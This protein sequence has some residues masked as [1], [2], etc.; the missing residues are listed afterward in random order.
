[1]NK[2]CMPFSCVKIAVVGMDFC[3]RAITGL[4]FYGSSPNS[5]VDFPNRVD[6]SFGGL[7]YSGAKAT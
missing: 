4:L 5:G 6:Y 2:I 1:M 3:K 7:P